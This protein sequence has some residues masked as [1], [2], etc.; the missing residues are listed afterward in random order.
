L[1]DAAF[2]RFDTIPACDGRTHDDG[3]YRASKR[4][5]VKTQDQVADKR[6]VQLR[7]SKASR[8]RAV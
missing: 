8:H 1:R 3:L 6:H 7:H 4:G 5:A 2:S